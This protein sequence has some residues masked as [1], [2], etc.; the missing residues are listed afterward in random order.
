MFVD[1]RRFWLVAIGVLVTGCAD[2]P[3]PLATPSSSPSAPNSLSDGDMPPSESRL[4]V[5]MSLTLDEYI[6]SGMPAHDRTWSGTDMTTAAT[7]LAAIAQQTP[8]RLPRYE[9]ERSGALFARITAGSNL[10]FHVNDSLPLQTRLLDAFQY[11]QSCNQI[12]LLYAN[13]FNQGATGDSEIIELSGA[14]LRTWVVTIKLMN[15]F[16]P[17]IDKDDSTYAVRMDAIKTMKGSTATA[18]H[19]SLDILTESSFYRTSELKRFTGYVEATFPDI[20]PELPDGSRSEA[21][22]RLRSLLADP[23]M[24]HLRPELDSLVATVERTFASNGAR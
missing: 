1:S 5:D 23:K 19:A 13:S 21:L 10:D 14:Q 4:P 8:G 20:L 17:S 16:V 22:T 18:V 7:V 2:R 6:E 11:M 12:L 9:S 24:Q 15:E 3:L